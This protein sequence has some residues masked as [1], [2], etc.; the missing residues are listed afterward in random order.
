MENLSITK[1]QGIITC[2]PIENKPK[3][4]SKK[5]R[6]LTFFDTVFKILVASRAIGKDSS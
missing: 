4:L 2:L 3:Q 1:K 6:S 5:S